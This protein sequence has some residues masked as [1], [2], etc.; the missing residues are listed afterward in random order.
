MA[1]LTQTERTALAAA[2]A[3]QSGTALAAT[4]AL[5]AA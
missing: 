1:T 4:L 2:A 3:T 5:L